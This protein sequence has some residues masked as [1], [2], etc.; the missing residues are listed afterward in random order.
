MKLLS[1][2]RQHLLHSC[3]E[4]GPMIV[5]LAIL[6]VF[7]F[8]ACKE[9]QIVAL[10]EKPQPVR[11]VT[12]QESARSVTLE[13]IGTTG[14]EAIKKYS[15]KIPGKIDKIFVAKGETITR[16]QKLAR[17][18]KNEV[19]LALR[20][21]E[22][23]VQKATNAYDESE[24]FL[25][26]VEKLFTQGAV[27]QARLE[28]AR[29]DRD[30]KKSVSEQA[31]IG[32]ESKRTVMS[33]TLMVSDIQGYVV[34]VLNEPGEIVGAGY[35]VVI[36]RGDIQ[37]VNVGVSQRDIKKL[38]VG[39][40]A[41]VRVDEVEGTG[42]ITRVSQ[43]P[44]R[45]S[46]TYN[47]EVSLIGKLEEQEFYIGSIAKVVFD[48]GTKSGI[49]IPITCVLTDGVD[50]VLVEKNGRAL[51]KNVELGNIS[52][53]EIEVRGLEPGMNVIVEGMKNIKAGYP[54]LATQEK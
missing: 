37:I 20:A 22:L 4:S 14:S 31:N 28:K 1:D 49:W 2:W 30:I 11:V 38:A 43:I 27:D 46:R 34:D 6:G 21:A 40:K 32:Y 53:G 48:I 7:L 10:E 3:A 50:Y 5:L 13:Y 52:S 19:D 26:K 23:D 51:R 12:V 24:R 33:D 15:F 44:D 47:V 35:P 9:R 8:S 41:T 25:Q 54:V 16:G 36:V 45:Q 42:E 29:L 17:L 39:T 18:K